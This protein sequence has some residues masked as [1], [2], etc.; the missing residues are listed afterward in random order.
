MK[1]NKVQITKEGL[2]TLK[3]ELAQLMEEKRPAL[4]KR[5]ARARDFGDL[6]EN[7]EYASARDELA[8]TEDRIT[9]LKNTL[10]QA[11]VI[12]NNKK[13]NNGQV[14]LGDQIV[15]KVNGTA[16]TYTLVGE[17]E[18][19]PMKAKISVSSPMGKAL[20]GKKKGDQ[21][22]VE[23]PGGKTKYIIQKVN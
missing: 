12:Q 5:V 1:I 11:V 23:A 3:K 7:S 18:A 14:A 17:L 19:D 20:L 13:S 21:V 16:K 6:S 9:E 4:I 22:E 8:F 2:E 15:V 10:N